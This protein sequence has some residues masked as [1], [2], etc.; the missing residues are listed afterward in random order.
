MT[1]RPNYHLGSILLISFC[2]DV[3]SIKVGDPS[4]A[5]FQMMSLKTAE[6][7]TINVAAIQVFVF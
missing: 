5:A 1:N 3:L 6:D 4:A 2:E 7:I